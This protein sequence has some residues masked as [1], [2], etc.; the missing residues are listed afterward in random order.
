MACAD[1]INSLFQF[2]T[3]YWDVA[4]AHAQAAILRKTAGQ[5]EARQAQAEEETTTAAATAAGQA[6]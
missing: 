6:R 3:N 5:W 1:T 2:K 4:E